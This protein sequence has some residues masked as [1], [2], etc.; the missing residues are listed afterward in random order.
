MGVV[1]LLDSLKQGTSSIKH[2]G[3]DVCRPSMYMFVKTVVIIIIIIIIMN[4]AGLY[5]NCFSRS[6][7]FD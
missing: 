5:I 7:P 2:L 3:L 1:V 6:F 4:G